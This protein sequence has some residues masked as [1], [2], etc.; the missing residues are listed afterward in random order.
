[1]S[2]AGYYD[3]Y[4]GDNWSLICWRGAVTSA[5]RGKRG[6]AFLREALAA[7]DALPEPAL[8][9]NDLTVAGAFCTLGA[10]GKARGADL[11]A[12]DTYDHG[13]LSSLFGI[14]EALAREIMYENDEG[15]YRAETPRARWERMRA[16]IVKHLNE[17][18]PSAPRPAASTTLASGTEE[19]TAEPV[20]SSG[21][22]N[23]QEGAPS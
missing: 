11:G 18:Q 19:V 17:D 21:R 9:P 15:S 22:A 7:L 2:R 4:D 16:W 20:T 14:S 23:N 6:Q 10:V 13:S 3:D 12:V 8:V 1:M 5:I